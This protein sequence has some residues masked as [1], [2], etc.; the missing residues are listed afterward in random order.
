MDISDSKI[1]QMPLTIAPIPKRSRI[2]LE[3]PFNGEPCR[4]V[5]GLITALIAKNPAKT[6]M[7]PKAAAYLMPLMVVGLS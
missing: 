3:L 1:I 5:P 2:I 6:S 4:D 7:V